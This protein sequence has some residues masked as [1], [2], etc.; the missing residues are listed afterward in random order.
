MILFLVPL[1]GN[2]CSLGVPVNTLFWSAPPSRTTCFSLF[3][4]VHQF[5]LSHQRMV[6]SLAVCPSVHPV[7]LPPQTSRFPSELRATLYSEPFQQF[8]GEYLFVLILFAVGSLGASEASCDWS[9]RWLLSARCAWHRSPN[10]L[11]CC[12]SRG[13]CFGISFYFVLFFLVLFSSAP[14]RFLLHF[15]RESRIRSSFYFLW[16]LPPPTLPNQKENI[17]KQSK[18]SQMSPSRGF[19]GLRKDFWPRFSHIP[20][21]LP[22][23]LS[24]FVTS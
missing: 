16:T 5:G 10:P 19:V 18:C 23:L 2:K 7:R 9:V 21:T 11:V 4:N 15:C 6:L 12:S 14:H 24:V 20:K 3:S 22:H 13:F 1:T 8:L 17:E